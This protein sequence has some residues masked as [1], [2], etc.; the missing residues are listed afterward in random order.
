MRAKPTPTFKLK[1]TDLSEPLKRYLEGQGY[2]VNCEV[3]HCDMT[4]TKDDA[5][6]IIEL[7]LKMSLRFLYQGL[8]RKAITDSVY[9]A[10]PVEGSKSTPPE[11]R[12]LKALLKRLEIG[13][14]LVRFLKTKTKV[15]IIQ[16]PDSWQAPKRPG[17]TRAILREIQS[18]PIEYNVAGASG[19]QPKITAYRKRVLQIAKTMDDGETWSPAAV[20]KTGCDSTAGQILRLNHYGWFVRE[21]RGKYRLDEAG[22]EALKDYSDIIESN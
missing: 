2:T 3:N 1:E 16:H 17:K 13:L 6:L 19:Q 22:K 4:A 14:I 9:L 20:K 5:L 12:N 11:F 7:K 21:D 15:E 18:R 10:L 8:N